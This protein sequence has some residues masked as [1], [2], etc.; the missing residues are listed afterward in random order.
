MTATTTARPTNVRASVP[1][2]EPTLEA[3]AAPL[4]AGRLSGVVSP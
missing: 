3:W 1:E 4:S 2:P